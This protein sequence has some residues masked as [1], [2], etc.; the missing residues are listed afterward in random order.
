MS[1]LRLLLLEEDELRANRLKTVFESSEIGYN[2]SHVQAHTGFQEALAS[3]KHDVILSGNFN[4]Q[5]GIT[6]VIKT[7]RAAGKNIPY[8]IIT[9]P[10]SEEY[11]VSLMKAGSFNFVL[12]ER[13]EKLPGAILQAIEKYNLSESREQILN[14]I[15][16]REAFM[17]EAER[18]ARF[19]SWKIEVD[20]QTTWWSDENYRILGYE[21]GE[22][23][24]SWDNFFKQVHPE[25]LE[26]TKF[27]LDEAVKNHD[28]KKYA[29]RVLDR[30]GSI[31]YIQAEIFVTRDA[32]FNVVRMNGVLRDMSDQ[33]QAEKRSVENEE[34]YFNLF[35]NNPCPLTVI[36]LESRR[37]IDVNSAALQLH[38]YDKGDLV[39]PSVH[40]QIP[41]SESILLNIGGATLASNTNQKGIWKIT[42]KDG[43][44]ILVAI[45]STEILVDGKA[46]KLILSEDISDRLSSISRLKESEARLLNSQR[47]AHIGSWEIDLINGGTI[48][49]SEETYRIFGVDHPV[50]DITPE[51]F[52]TIV[53]TED[54]HL[55]DEAYAHAVEN[56][57]AYHAEFRIILRNGVERLVSELGE[58]QFDPT[59]GAPSKLTGTVQDITERRNARLQLQKSE[60]NLRSIFENAHTAYVLLDTELKI[61]SFNKPANRFSTEHLDKPLA[62][63]EYAIDYFT[64][65]TLAVVRKSLREALLG[66]NI[67]YEVS[68]PDETGVDKWYYAHFHPVRSDDEH[69]LGV[70]MSLRDITERKTSE[71][72]EKKITTELI[73]RNKDL[74]QFAYIISHNLRA[75]VAN[76]LGISDALKEG[77]IEEEEEK[78]EFLKGLFDSAKK[79]DTV[80]TDLN[81]ILQLKHGLNENKEKVHFSNLVNDIKYTI[82]GV[83]ENEMFQIKYDF[84]EIDEMITLKSYL[85]SIFYNLISNSIKYKRPGIVPVIEIRS[86]KVKGGIILTFND[87][88][89]GIDMEKNG[90]MLFGLYKRFNSHV[91]EGKGMGLFMVKTQVE[92]LGGRISVKSKVNH[93]TEFRI[94]FSQ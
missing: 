92:T 46:S 65:A 27:V 66:A 33:V 94:E 31:R 60:A 26:P 93:G 63:G 54:H 55:L 43:E 90:N 64:D 74:E 44:S 89:L 78:E 91:A 59:T 37:I 51:L 52:L 76:I 58:L 57:G 72:Q 67:N 77:Y 75:P 80:I 8:I 29:F 12:K 18:I 85:H 56:G 40:Q 61:V 79:L 32:D 19:G 4:E 30:S 28:K 7:I 21:P 81:R 35:E 2:V 13:L 71:L 84:S 38:G 53:H 70:I 47:I 34:K 22:V 11:A 62:E 73:Q 10:I 6:G 82:A 83:S 1:K 69:I 86:T 15:L 23:Q 24:P 39:L 16:P 48:R 88:G 36:D 41:D 20:Q 87:N 14:D 3:D 25:D 45:T 49:W 68:Y 9:N 5:E 17:K 50:E 42:K